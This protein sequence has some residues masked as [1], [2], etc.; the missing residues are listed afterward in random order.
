M[1]LVE[2]DGPSSDAWETEDMIESLDVLSDYQ[3]KVQNES[4]Y[5]IDAGSIQQP[6]GSDH[7][8]P[9]RLSKTRAVMALKQHDCVLDDYL[10]DDSDISQKPVTTNNAPKK[11]ANQKQGRKTKA[12]ALADIQHA[13]RLKRQKERLELN[14]DEI[15]DNM[16]HFYGKECC[17]KCAANTYRDA[18]ESNDMKLLETALNDKEIP[19]PDLE[20]KPNG[21]SFV[22]YAIVLQREVFAEVVEKHDKTDKSSDYPIQFLTYNGGS[23]G[24]NH[25]LGTYHNRSFR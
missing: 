15:I 7:S 16:T 20:D 6:E 13:D 4:G 24:R 18:L 25:G 10:S 1:Y 9:S 22:Q 5:S 2:R 11:S 21:L 14:P 17:L 3:Q 23:T 8:R 12:E 19:S